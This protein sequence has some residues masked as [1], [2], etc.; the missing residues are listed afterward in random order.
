LVDSLEFLGAFALLSGMST[1]E[2]LRFIFA[3]YDFDCSQQ[4]SM[5]ETI[6]AL[7]STVSGVSKLCGFD[8]PLDVE[9]EGIAVAAFPADLEVA[10]PKLSAADFVTY[11]CKNPEVTSWMEYCSGLPESGLQPPPF[12]DRAAAGIITRERRTHGRGALHQ[13]AMDLDGGQEELLRIERKGMAQ[14]I[15]PQLPWQNTVAFTEPS[16]LPSHLPKEAPNANMELEWCYGLNACASRGSVQYTLKGNIVYPSGAVGVVY[17]PGS[18]TQQYCITHTDCISCCDAYKDEKP[19]SDA[20]IARTLVATGQ[21]GVSPKVVIWNAETSQL[22]ATFR[23]FHTRGI[24]Q[25]KFSPEGSLVLSVG[26]DQDSSVAVH[27]WKSGTTIFTAPSSDAPVVGAAFTAESAFVTCGHNHVNFWTKAGGSYQVSE[28]IFGRVGFLQPQLCIAGC[29]DRVVSGSS[30]GHLYVWEGRNCT[31]CM[32]AATGA[33]TC[34]TAATDKGFAM[35]SAD[36]KIQLWSLELEM[37]ALFEVRGLGSLSTSIHSLAWE[38]TS[39]KILVATESAEVFEMADAEGVSIHKGAVI[40]GHY[41]NGC[42]GLAPHPSIPERYITVGADRTI[43]VW[44]RN[45]KKCI[46]LCVLDT[47]ARCCAYNP[48]GTMIGIGLGG[49][50][51]PDAGSLSSSSE[52]TPGTKSAKSK[53]EGAY[54]ILKESDL[55]V[56][57]EARDSKRP[58]NA[59]RWSPDGGTLAVASDDGSVYLYNSGKFFTRDF[60]AKAKCSGF[61]GGATHVDFSGDSQFLQANSLSSRELLF[62]DAERGSQVT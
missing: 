25:V 1:E 53:K 19:G 23:G 22:L 10:E 62:F 35:G 43:R 37:G 50:H 8:P 5:D 9:L 40:S 18:H 21:F 3:I 59:I 2:K 47:P 49:G 14:E 52:G 51:L 60:I 55:T 45:V 61:K 30:S 17:N 56:V 13:A 32:K 57:H 16:T 36:G 41:G 38:P 6:L 58:I 12:T 54:I 11:C 44:D 42:R 31:R 29:G 28:G 34:V 48:D 27:H 20:L 46:R 24:G 4:L 15:E 26:L 33:I 7:R 39:H